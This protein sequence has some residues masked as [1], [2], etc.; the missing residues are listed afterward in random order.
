MPESTAD[1]FY[2]RR[3]IKRGRKEKRKKKNTHAELSL[4]NPLMED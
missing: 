2:S 1:W 4:T 3:L